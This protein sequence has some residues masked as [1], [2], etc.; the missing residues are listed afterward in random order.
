MLVAEPKL[1]GR[2]V[3][4]PKLSPRTLL[5]TAIFLMAV[6]PAVNYAAQFG[7][8]H[9]ILPAGHAI[10]ITDHNVVGITCGYGFVDNTTFAVNQFR[11][12]N[13]TIL[14]VCNW[15]G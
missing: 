10:P 13:G 1:Q 11:D 15:A 14:K 2:V 12:G 7:G 8:G 4:R 5:L 3:L 6:I 9:S